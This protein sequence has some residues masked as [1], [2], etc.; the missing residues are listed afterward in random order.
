M[1]AC[2]AAKTILFILAVCRSREVF[3]DSLLKLSAAGT[4]VADFLVIIVKMHII[5]NF[6][7]KVHIHFCGSEIVVF[8]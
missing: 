5:N 6:S 4:L 2:E 7:F 8:H 3:P 1:N